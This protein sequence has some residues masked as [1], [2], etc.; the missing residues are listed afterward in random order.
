MRAESDHALWCHVRED[1][2]SQS[3]DRSISA[4]PTPSLAQKPWQTLRHPKKAELSL[5]PIQL[6]STHSSGLQKS[7]Q[8]S[9]M[10]GRWGIKGLWPSF[11]G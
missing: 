10:K 2:S 4:H 3:G 11:I 9:L 8:E 1:R 7:R 6:P 5:F